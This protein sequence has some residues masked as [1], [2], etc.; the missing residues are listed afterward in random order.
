MKHL[1]PS[2]LVDLAEGTLDASRAAHADR[3]DTCRGAAGAICDTLHRASA[4]ADVPEPSPLFWEHLSTRVRD[5]VAGERVGTAGFGAWW[6][7]AMRGFVPVAAAAILLAIV[8]MTMTLRHE[9]V[10]V[11]PPIASA[12]VAV[13]VGADQDFD[14][15]IDANTNEAWEVLTA[16]AADLQLE[17]AHAAGL[18]VQPAT[19]DRAVQRLNSDELNELGRL[20]QTELKRAGN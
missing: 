8:S 18:G 11:A 20:L 16:A 7:T 3:C 15:A 2:E 14:T 6:S 9:P 5:G 17:D 10:S 4:A 13:G 1:T 12:P 19:V